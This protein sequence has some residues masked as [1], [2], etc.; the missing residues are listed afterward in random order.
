MS[1]IV[2]LTPQILRAIIAEEKKKIAKKVRA[3]K[4]PDDLEKVA[5]QTKEVEAKDMA[6][7]LVKDV[8]H[9]KELQKEAARLAA[10]LS[11]VNEARQEIRQHILE[12]L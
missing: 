2:N 11:E 5:S 7:T 3:K 8:N 9:Y 1:K 4:A 6:H 12:Q 10:R